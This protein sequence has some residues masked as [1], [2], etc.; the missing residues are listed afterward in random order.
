MRKL[1]SLMVA[2]CLLAGFSQLQAAV[3]V[4]TLDNLPLV[5]GPVR[6]LASLDDQCTATFLGFTY[7]TYSGSEVW[8]GGSGTFYMTGYMLLSSCQPND[9]II[10]YC[11]DLDH[12]LH[13][14]PYC[15]NIDQVLVRPAF[16][17]QY[18]AMAYLLAWYP[19]TNGTEDQLMQL[20]LW[21]MA[22]DQR[23]SS[24]TYGAPWYTING[25]RGYPNTGDVPV[26]PYVNT[27]FN[28]EPSVNSPADLR[29]L[30]VLGASDGMPK[31]VAMCDDQITITAG[32]RDS[33]AEFVRVP[34]TIQLL[35]GAAAAAAGNT[36]LRGV[37]LQMSA[38]AG[39]LS[40]TEAFTDAAGRVH[41]SITQPLG[42]HEDVHFQVCTNGA[43]LTTITPCDGFVNQQEISVTHCQLCVAMDIPGDTW[44]AAELAS[45]DVSANENGIELNWRSLSESRTSR[46]EVERCESGST[47]FALLASIPA[48]NSPSGHEYHYTDV[49]AQHG[50]V[51]R[52]RLADVNV[53]GARLTHSDL[54]RSASLPDGTTQ[55]SGYE[56]SS[57]YPNPF[58]PETTIRFN[59]AESGVTTLKVY[60]ITGHE[61]ATLADGKLA[62]GEHS[63][64][65]HGAN[66]PSGIYFYKLSTGSFTQTRKMVLAK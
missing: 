10:G 6:S 9:T 31:N 18:P 56:L 11:V 19:V 66:L 15:A 14:G 45:F 46:W 8:P 60:D 4:G 50:V 26:Y 58:N 35:R 23:S 29:V 13:Q 30:Y 36:S 59:L 24:A 42:S 39:T 49:T 25:G 57:N 1:L 55:V 33:V 28:T 48:A 44:L 17:E 21:K 40:A 2:L 34:V 53:N 5:T 61:V 7:G 62:A 64:T 20:S 27:V 3:R 47:D 38:S 41:V 65:F 32:R 52:Y 12:M 22:N 54:V 63:V 43:W 37:K 51:Y 16:A